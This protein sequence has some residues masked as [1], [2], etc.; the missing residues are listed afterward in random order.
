MPALTP[1]GALPETGN[2]QNFW[3]RPGFIGQIHTIVSFHAA[4][5]R[6]R[7][8]WAVIHSERI[9]EHVGGRTVLLFP[10]ILAQPTVRAVPSQH[11]SRSGKKTSKELLTAALTRKAA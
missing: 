10:V 11:S 8:A 1:E 9:D 2:F 7:E 6:Q 3:A 5:V 4:K